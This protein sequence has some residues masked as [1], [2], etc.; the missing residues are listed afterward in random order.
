[1]KTRRD[2]FKK[3]HYDYDKLSENLDNFNDVQIDFW[4]IVRGEEKTNPDND[5]NL[6]KWNTE[7]K[8]WDMYALYSKNYRQI[9]PNVTNKKSIQYNPTKRTYLIVKN[10]KTGLWEFPT[11]TLIWGETV[12]IKRQFLLYSLFR[13]AFKVYFNSDQP[14]FQMSRDLYPFEDKETKFVTYKGVYRLI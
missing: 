13:D 11:T 14:F 6:R 9:D 5:I 1:M 12:E 7:K 2:F 10:R 4:D 8:Q 3:Y